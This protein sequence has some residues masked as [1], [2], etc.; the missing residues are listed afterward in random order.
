MKTISNKL[1]FNL[2]LTLLFISECLG[3]YIAGLVIH[4]I[5]ISNWDLLIVFLSR[6]GVF[7]GI[8]ILI[9]LFLDK[10]IKPDYF[11]ISIS[12][13]NIQIKLY[14]PNRQNGLYFFSILF[15]I[16]NISFAEIALNKYEYYTF[17]YDKLKIRKNLHFYITNNNQIR[18]LEVNISLASKTKFQE[19]TESL[20]KFKLNVHSN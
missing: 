4:S 2:Y 9:S 15:Y 17:S 7:A 19:I 5:A 11:V 12:R 20:D 18:Q 10:Y 13:R 8:I 1:L 3:L 14:K 16:K 6:F